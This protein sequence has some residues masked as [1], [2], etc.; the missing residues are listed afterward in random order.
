M[1]AN[2]EQF[3]PCDFVYCGVVLSGK[4]MSVCIA[5]IQDN[6]EL[7]SQS[8]FP[9]KKSRE[10]S[11]GGI[12]RGASFSETKVSGLDAVHYVSRHSNEDDIIKWRARN[13]AAKT[14]DRSLKLEKDAKKINEIDEQLKSLRKLYSTY[15]KRND[16]A[17]LEA[18]EAAVLRSLR[19]PIR[20]AEAESD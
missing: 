1:T 12:Y 11:I 13:D 20:Q 10:L 2:A 7:G 9:H 16:H 14:K 15:R 17:G 19:T 3:I 8:F 4:E 5:S 18:L 6:G